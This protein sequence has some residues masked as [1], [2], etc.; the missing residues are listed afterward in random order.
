M[1]NVVFHI[2]CKAC[3]SEAKYYSQLN[4][5]EARPAELAAD[6]VLLEHAPSHWTCKCGQTS[7]DLTY[8]KQGLHDLFRHPRPRSDD[9]A[10]VQFTPLYKAGRIQD[11][12]AEFDALLDTTEDEETVQKYLEEHPVFW[13]FLSPLRIL[14]KPPVLTK[15]KADFG[16]LTTHKILYMVEIE[17]PRTRLINQDGSISAEIQRGADQ[18][19]DWQVV[20]GDHR[21]TLLS[22][23]G[24]K[25]SDVQE[26]RYILIGGLSKR[27]TAA[28][29]TKLRRSPFAS[30]TDFYCFDELGSVLHTLSQELRR[31]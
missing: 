28:G 1:R 25:E 24:L 5:I 2:G 21:L 26:I 9:Q 4:P 3:K 31:L 23:L 13:A 14:H 8:L 15:K 11:M 12:I 30:N 29:L 16:I 10:I 17:K 19:R 18:I 20:V 27:T 7:V 22:E 6:A